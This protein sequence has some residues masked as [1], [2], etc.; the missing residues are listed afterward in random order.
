MPQFGLAINSILDS[1]INLLGDAV[2]RSVFSTNVDIMPIGA[3]KSF[4][5]GLV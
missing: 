3:I 2:R 1:G 5:E 4:K